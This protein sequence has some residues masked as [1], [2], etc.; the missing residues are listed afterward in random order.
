MKTHAR[1]KTFSSDDGSEN[2][3]PLPIGEERVEQKKE[4]E[5]NF[6]SKV[7]KSGDTQEKCLK[8]DHMALEKVDH[9]KPKLE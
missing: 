6:L 7:E 5:R 2:W 4:K 3:K 8:S 9:G 1:E